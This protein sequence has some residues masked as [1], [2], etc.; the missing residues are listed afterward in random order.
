MQSRCPAHDPFHGLR[1]LEFRCHLCGA[2]YVLLSDELASRHHRCQ[3]C[4][5]RVLEVALHVNPALEELRGFTTDL[6]VSGLTFLA[7]EDVVVVEDYRKL[8]EQPRCPNY[9]SSIHCPPHA[10]TPADFKRLLGMYLWSLLFRYDIPVEAFGG[11]SRPEVGRLLHD[12]TAE[13]E[14]RARELGFRRAV[15]FSS[16][17]CK[18]TYCGEHAGCAALEDV[19]ACRF[20]EHARTSLSAVGVDSAELIRLAGWQRPGAD[21]T[22]SNRRAEGALLLGLVLL[23]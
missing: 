6:G 20:P 23:E 9:G 11:S 4:G 13:V 21:G 3:R 10:Q 5:R 7:A 19:A 2:E 15:G 18:N 1:P 14:R 16:G 22:P 17:G 12:T 8:C